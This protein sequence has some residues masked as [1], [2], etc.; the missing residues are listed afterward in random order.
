MFSI[1]EVSRQTGTSIET[2][3]YYERINLIPEPP[4]EGRY[5]S[6]GPEHVRM[7]LLVR[8][9]R[10]LGF[11]LVEVRTL[12]GLAATGQGACEEARSL[13]ASQIAAIRT[14]ISDLHRMERVL[15]DA[16]HACEANEHLGC[17]VI[18]R[19]V[20]GFR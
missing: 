11:A 16:V 3:R 8:R 20:V 1:G 5:R 4:R 7:L 17:P 10:Q 9:A 12:L 14:R 19:L 6:Y 15:V 18:D 2:I 13:A